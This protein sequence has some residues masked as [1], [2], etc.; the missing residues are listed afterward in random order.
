MDDGWTLFAITDIGE[1][2]R[3]T[4]EIESAAR[5]SDLLRAAAGVYL[6]RFDPDSGEYTVETG[7]SQSKEW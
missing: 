6:W 4:A 7:D 1:E 3:R 2:R 5:V